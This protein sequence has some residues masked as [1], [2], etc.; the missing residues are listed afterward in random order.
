MHT[1][2]LA[3]VIMFIISNRIRMMML[4]FWE[5]NFVQILL[6]RFLLMQSTEE[7]L[8]HCMRGQFKLAALSFYV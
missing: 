1:E 6:L 8:I 5:L 3:V 2:F 4:F 7:F